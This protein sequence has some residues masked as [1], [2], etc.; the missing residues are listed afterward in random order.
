MTTTPLPALVRRFSSP[1]D[2]AT[3]EL[4][5]DGSLIRHGIAGRMLLAADHRFV[6]FLLD[7][8]QPAR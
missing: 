3:M 8:E 4:L 5:A 7:S 6:R 2:R 1:A